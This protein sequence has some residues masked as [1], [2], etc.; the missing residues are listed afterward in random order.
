MSR[1]VLLI[2]LCGASAGCAAMKSCCDDYCDH[3]CEKDPVQAALLRTYKQE[4]RDYLC[5]PFMPLEVVQ[6]NRPHL[7]PAIADLRFLY[8][9]DNQIPDAGMDPVRAIYPNINF[10]Y[11]NSNSG[12]SNS[13]PAPAPTAPPEGLP[14][15]PPEPDPDLL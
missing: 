1:H 4:T 7:A 3:C 15:A 13:G 11:P 5:R 12:P 6:S 2:L 14:P 10:G 9:A 8:A